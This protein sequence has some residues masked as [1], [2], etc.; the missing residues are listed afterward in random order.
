MGLRPASHCFRGRGNDYE[1]LIL[2]SAEAQVLAAV[3]VAVEI[4]ADVNAA[5]VFG[6]TA[7]DAATAVGYDT[8]A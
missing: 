5:G 6:R 2:R 3:K 7:L 8:V 4:G 1:F